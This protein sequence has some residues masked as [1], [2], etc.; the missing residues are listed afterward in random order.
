[1]IDPKSKNRV[2]GYKYVLV[3][4]WITSKND[5]QMHYVYP[6]TVGV[7]YG[8]EADRV[9]FSV[10]DEGALDRLRYSVNLEGL[11]ILRPDPTGKYELPKE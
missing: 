3:G 1:M 2:S 5:G 6:P 4:G 11:I 8:V 10:D 9:G 7:L